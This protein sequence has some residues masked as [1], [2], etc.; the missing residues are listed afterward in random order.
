MDKKEIL[1]FIEQFTKHVEG[2]NDKNNIL[3]FT[4]STCQW[5]KKCKRYLDDKN[6]KYRY[7]DVDQISSE[8]KGKILEFLKENYDTRI[9]Y[10]FIV[11][12]DKFIVGYDPNKYDEMFD[13]GEK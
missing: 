12:D 10:P 4:L 1:D 8:N 6:I 9:S 2:K 13:V 3:A 5:C 7:I 11:C